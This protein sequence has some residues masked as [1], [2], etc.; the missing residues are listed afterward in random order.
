MDFINMFFSVK[1]FLF[2]Q[3]AKDK[4]NSTAPMKP[5]YLSKIVEAKDFQNQ[6]HFSSS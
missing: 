4:N 3:K 2:L 6:G 5:E 1:C